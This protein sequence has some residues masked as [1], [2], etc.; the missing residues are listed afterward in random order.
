VHENA[1]QL[2]GLCIGVGIGFD[3]DADTDPD[4]ESF[5]DC[6]RVFSKQESCGVH[7]SQ[8]KS[9]HLRTG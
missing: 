7:S 6:S 4:P 5:L 1:L 2:W 8:M 3:S 9:I